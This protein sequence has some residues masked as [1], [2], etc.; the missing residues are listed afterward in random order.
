MGSPTRGTSKGGRPWP[1]VAPIILS[2]E[3]ISTAALWCAGC[4]D[5]WVSPSRESPVLI[6]E[7]PVEW[8]VP[9]RGRRHVRVFL[10]AG[11]DDLRVCP[12]TRALTYLP[13]AR[14]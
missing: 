5:R 4:A 7:A 2:P 11:L 14:F 6:A 1:P 3:N 8:P 9:G 10:R 13:G 12:A